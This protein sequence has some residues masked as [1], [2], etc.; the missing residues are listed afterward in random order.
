MS[1]LSLWR[2]KGQRRSFTLIELLTVVVIIA[3]LVALSTTAVRPIRVT[4]Q[5]TQCSNNMR[6]IG[7]GLFAYA[8][9]HDNAL[10]PIYIN[11]PGSGQQDYWNWVTWPYIYPGTTPQWPENDTQFSSKATF[12]WKPNVF[13]CPAT[14]KGVPRR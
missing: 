1:K 12:K 5:Q 9:D 13:R 3:I 10:P 4:M 11:Y 2:I 6:Q 8:V 7:Q 14:A